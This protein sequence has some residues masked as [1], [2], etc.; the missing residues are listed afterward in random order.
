MKRS[1][2][3]L[4]L[5]LLAALAPASAGTITYSDRT[6]WSSAV[7]NI[8]NFDSGTQTAGT[9]TPF[10]TSAGLALTDLQ[11]IGYNISSTGTLYDVT[12]VN[13]S[14]GQPWYQWNSGS[15]LRS[16]DKT[17]TN[18]IYLRV[19]FTNPVNAFGFDF[20]GSGGVSSSVTISPD[21]LAASTVATNLQPNFTFFGVTSDTQTFSF[22]NIYIND[23]GRYL[24]LDNI[25][26]ATFTAPVVTP[27]P[28][29][30]P[31]PGTFAQLALGAGLLAF[32]RHRFR[33][34]TE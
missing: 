28:A 8:V 29:E 26:Y 14:A 34:A 2:T 18:T 12:R 24:A 10:S 22:A 20:G 25:A 33:A 23:A 11:I 4:G 9:A 17:A 27:P 6:T 1:I 30:T 15:I 16:G 32:A 7:T 19:Q 31:E 21:G 13:A 3:S 5:Y